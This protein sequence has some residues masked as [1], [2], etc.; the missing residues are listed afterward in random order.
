M[1]SQCAWLM[2]VARRWWNDNR[3]DYALVLNA[4][5]SS[6]KFCV[7]QRPQ[8]EDWN[9]ASRGQ[10]EGIG[11]SQRILAKDAAN[12]I[13]INQPEAHAGDG[14]AALDLLAGWLRSM[15]P[16]AG[17]LGVGFTACLTSTSRLCVGQVLE[18]SGSCPC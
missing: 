14:G 9:L 4:G 15:Y 7:Y 10:I 6:L 17:V 2:P 11:V 5:S 8:D 1:Q 16:G 3:A 12:R 13:L 18:S